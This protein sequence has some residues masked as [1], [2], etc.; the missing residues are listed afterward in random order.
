MLNQDTICALATAPL[1]AGVAIIRLSGAHAK[2][3]VTQLC[4]GFS[5]IPAKQAHYGTLVW[6]EELLDQAILLYFQAPHSFTGEDVVEIQ[7]HGGMAVIEAIIQALL[8]QPN[9]RQA[10]AGEFSKRAFLNQKLD[11]IAAEGLADLIAAETQ[12]QRHQAQQQLQGAWG[13]QF[14]AW[15]EEVLA[16]LAQVEAAIDFPDEE[17]EILASTA[18]Q[19][20]ITALL[21]TLTTAQENRTGERIRDGFKLAVVGKPN[22]GK[23][24]L[25]NLLTGRET[26]IVS[27][28]AGTTRDVVEARLNID[29]FPIVLADTAGMR[30]ST[31]SIEQEGVR[32]AAQ[33]A[34]QADIV[35]LVVTASEWPTVAPAL[36]AYVEQPN[37]IVVISKIDESSAI[38]AKDLPAKAC[39]LN[40]TDAASGPVLLEKLAGL[41]KQFYGGSQSAALLTRQRHRDAVLLAKQALTDTLEQTQPELMAQSLREAAAAIGS[42]TGRTSNEDVLDLVFSTFCIGK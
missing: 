10:E 36:Q 42:I 5:N 31:D 2:T 32:R 16:L 21:V 8:S 27:P 6:Q 7:C 17:L 34:S 39:G 9:V 18:L 22:A 13:N 26:A 33:Q 3:A 37:S 4:P 1:A 23:S 41:I 14:E 40:L 28:Q 38:A 19:Q 15:R 24:T 20:K 25:T 29:G 12:A 35:I 11:L 30:D